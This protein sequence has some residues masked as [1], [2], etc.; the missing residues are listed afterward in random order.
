MQYVYY[1]VLQFIFNTVAKAMLGHCLHMYS[2]LY[3]VD[4]FF[5]TM[6]LM[7]AIMF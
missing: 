2:L 5:R 4:N 7:D 3:T 1:S 6:N